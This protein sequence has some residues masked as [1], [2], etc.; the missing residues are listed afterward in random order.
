MSLCQ[1]HHQ[2]HYHPALQLCHLPLPF[3]I[4]TQPGN[5]S[6]QAHIELTL[7]AFG[8]VLTAPGM[9]MPP[10]PSMACSPHMPPPPTGHL[11]GGCKKKARRSTRDQ[12]R[13]KGSRVGDR[14]VGQASRSVR[15]PPSWC[16]SF[17]T[18]LHSRNSPFPCLWQPFQ[19]KSH[20]RASMGR[21]I[22]GGD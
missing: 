9:V 3:S 16:G 12:R 1:M 4:P 19:E 10:K 17:F 5:N 2:V 13:T 15:P 6:C 7:L 21:A 8:T 20:F 11:V 22:D 18:L 14:R